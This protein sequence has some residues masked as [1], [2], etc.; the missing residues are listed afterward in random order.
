MKNDLKKERVNLRFD[1]KQRQTLERM[2]D[3]LS[4]TMSGVVATALSL[5]TVAIA[6]Q[7]N[8]NSLGIVR[9]GKVIKEI[10]G[11]TRH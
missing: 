11:I 10:I 2:A 9:D 1:E 4:T 7:K 5:L 6:E 3:E 8:G